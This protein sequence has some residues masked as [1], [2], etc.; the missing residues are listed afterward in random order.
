MLYLYE[1]YLC[2]DDF[3]CSVAD[4]THSSDPCHL[5]LRFE[6]LR[7]AFLFCHLLYQQ[8]K[9]ILCLS[10]DVSQ[11]TVQLAAQYQI[12]VQYRTVFFDIIQMLSAPDTDGAFLGDWQ[13]QTR[14]VIISMQFIPKSVA[15]VVDI[16][17]HSANLRVLFV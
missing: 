15:V 12:G 17:F 16:F 8:S 7:N 6:L 4:A 10:I 3:F 13:N 11:I 2:I 14:N 5:I 1:N 9:P